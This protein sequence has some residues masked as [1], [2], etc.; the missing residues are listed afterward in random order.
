MT[1]TQLRFFIVAAQME[2]LSNAA[3]TLYISQSSLSKNIASLENELGV[4]LFD[5]K[6]K[7]LRLN[8]AGEKFLQSCQR[9]TGELDEALDALRQIDSARN[10]RIHIGVE[11]EIGPLVA[12][13]A[14]F[15][16]MHPEVS[17]EVDSS[18]GENEHPDINDYEI[19]VY[20]ESQKYNRFRG[21]SYYS[22]EYF[23]ALPRGAETLELKGPVSNRELSGRN[24]V[25]LHYGDQ[26]YEYPRQVCRSLMIETTAEHHVDSEILKHKMIAEGI[27]VGFVSSENRAYYQDDPQILLRPLVSSRFTRQIMICFKREKHLSALAKEFCDYV[28]S[29]LSIEE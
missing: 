12:W 16:N 19:M 5:R 28:K 18:L 6:G 23:L 25:F 2:N 22:D 3:S 27:A 4:R 26:S 17:F 15:Q 29:C 20:P 7:S 8:A 24:M 1:I 9:I 14:D 13:M 21:Y 11:G 10:V